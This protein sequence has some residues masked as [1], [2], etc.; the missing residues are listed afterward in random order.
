MNNSV[1]VVPCVGCIHLTPA[2]ATGDGFRCQHPQASETDY[3]TGMQFSPRAQAVRMAGPCG[4]AG[5]LRQTTEG[6]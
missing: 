5:A 3:V 2:S 1:D 6:R 4:V